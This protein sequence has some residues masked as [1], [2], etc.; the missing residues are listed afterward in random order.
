MKKPKAPKY[1]QF[2]LI[3]TI[4]LVFLLFLALCNP[5]ELK[6]SISEAKDQAENE[7]L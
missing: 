2:K 6:R 4:L 5:L 3:I 1:N 7:V